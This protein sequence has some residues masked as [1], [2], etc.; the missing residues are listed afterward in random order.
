MFRF[1]N[2]QTNPPAGDCKG[3]QTVRQDG[4]LYEPPPPADI[5]RMKRNKIMEQKAF[6]LLREILSK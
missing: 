5:E 4:S 3:Q 2:K 1:Y 6:A